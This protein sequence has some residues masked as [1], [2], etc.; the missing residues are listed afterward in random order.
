VTRIDITAVS[1]DAGRVSVNVKATPRPGGRDDSQRLLVAIQDAARDHL[2]C[3]TTG[4]GQLDPEELDDIARRVRE[5]FGPD[6]R[7]IRFTGL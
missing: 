1:D 4:D 2:R 3:L 7:D 6:G 5:A